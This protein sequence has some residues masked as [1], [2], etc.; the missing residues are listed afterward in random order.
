MGEYLPFIRKKIQDPLAIRNS[1]RLSLDGGVQSEDSGISA[2]NCLC[3]SPQKSWCAFIYNLD[4]VWAHRWCKVPMLKE[5]PYSN[6]ILSQYLFPD[7]EFHVR[8]KKRRKHLEDQN[9]QENS[10]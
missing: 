1:L 9:L 8:W 3:V 7:T 6:C 4:G 5:D 10:A 2:I